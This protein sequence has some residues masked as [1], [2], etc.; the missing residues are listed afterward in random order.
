MALSSSGHLIEDNYILLPPS[1]AAVFINGEKSYRKFAEMK[2]QEGKSD[3]RITM[4]G[5][6]PLGQ[7]IT[8]KKRETTAL[9][10]VLEPTNKEENTAK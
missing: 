1:G 6:K 10:L 4:N 5:Y 2:L 3:L 9:N 7:K 8:I